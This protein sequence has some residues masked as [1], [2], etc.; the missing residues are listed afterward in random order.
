MARASVMKAAKAGKTRS[1]ATKSA[2]ASGRAAAVKKNPAGKE[3]L[4]SE[5]EA[6]VVETPVEVV[7]PVKVAPVP[8]ALYFDARWYLETYPDV[9]DAGIDPATHY[10]M[11][12]FREGRKPNAAFDGKAYLAANPDLE[13]YSEDLFAHYVF[14]GASEGRRIKP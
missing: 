6:E 13:G 5:F 10:Q 2:T 11:N 4:L 14:F 12:G 8:E 3:D 9:A 7:V 1:S